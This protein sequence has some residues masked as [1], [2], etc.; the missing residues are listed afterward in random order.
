[1]RMKSKTSSWRDFAD[2]STFNCA[3]FF[4][5]HAQNLLS[6]WALLYL[7]ISNSTYISI[8][9]RVLQAKYICLN[10]I[11]A[12]SAWTPTK[13]SIQKTKDKDQVDTIKPKCL[14]YYYAL[15]MLLRRADLFGFLNFKRSL[16]CKFKC[17]SLWHFF[18]FRDKRRKSPPY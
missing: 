2:A 5:R 15:V 12:N 7:L 3:I 6:S 18:H 10:M 8:Y 13:I 1:M 17:P 4:Q 9:F 11:T 14:A 16:I